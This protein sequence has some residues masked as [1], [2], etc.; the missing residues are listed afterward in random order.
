MAWT[1]AEI[2]EL[3]GASKKIGRM[4]SYRRV[5][6]IWAAAS[7]DAPKGKLGVRTLLNNAGHVV[8]SYYFDPIDN[9]GDQSAVCVDVDIVPEPQSARGTAYVATLTYESRGT[10]PRPDEPLDSLQEDPVNRPYSVRGATAHREQTLNVGNF[11][12]A[13]RL[14]DGTQVA[15]PMAKRPLCSSAGEPSAV[16]PNYDGSTMEWVIQKNLLT[17]AW[18]SNIAKDWANA[19][20]NAT[21]NGLAAY[22]VRIVHIDFERVWEPSAENVAGTQYYSVTF[23]LEYKSDFWY[24]Q[25]T[26]QGSFEI[27]QNQRSSV[28]LKDGKPVYVYLD[29][30]GQVLSDADF[31]AGKVVVVR[32]LPLDWPA[33]SFATIPGG[34]YTV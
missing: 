29:G 19:V 16:V 24:F 14:N 26:D 4:R 32:Y 2:D 3:G 28:R 11:L 1:I 30:L 23:H 18:N 13:F 31:T 15:A 9:I 21:W 7:G 22:T 20:N 34:P 27:R 17:S 33:K 8:G 6:R 12:G 5:L 25:Y 10:P